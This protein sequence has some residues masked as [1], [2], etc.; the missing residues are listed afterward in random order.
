[1]HL[2]T[3][4]RLFSIGNGRLYGGPFQF[5]KRAIIDDGLLDLV[6]FKRLDYLEIIKY[7]HDV[8]FS[9]NIR[10]PDIEYVQTQRFRIISEPRCS[11]GAGRRTG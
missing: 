1:M 8:V 5:C 10:V 2:L 11:G 6:V 9:S 7:L 4:D 3:R